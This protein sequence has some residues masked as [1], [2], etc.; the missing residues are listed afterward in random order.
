MG[1][2][3]L[4]SI[5]ATETRLVHSASANDDY[6]ISIALPFHYKERT[7]QNWPV[8]YVLDGNLHFG[9]V[10]D[11]VRFMNIRV[12]FCNELPDALVVGI[13]YQVSGTLTETLHQVMHLRLRDF[14]LERDEGGEAFMQEHFPIADPFPSGEALRFMKFIKSEVIP[15]VEA[16][17]RA[18]RTD[19]TL[20]GH[21]YG[22]NFALSTLFEEPG[23]FQ[24]CVAASF[25]PLLEEERHFAGR[26]DALP[27][28]LHMVWEGQSKE[29]LGSAGA[30]VD[31]IASRGYAGLRLTSQTIASTHCAMVPFAY[32]SGLIQVFGSTAA[33]RVAG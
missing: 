5:P 24:R 22:A 25:D 15:M 18:D 33:G 32:Q 29:E 12:G 4:A 8:I 2:P 16:E 1:T 23:L 3:D 9:L 27:V 30:L 14:T 28:R 17:Y 21:S 11:M 26:G 7:E 20:L 19:R 13:G 10:V 6:L 31:Q